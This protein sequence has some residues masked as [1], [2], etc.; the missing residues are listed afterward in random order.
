M[1]N[2]GSVPSQI[3]LVDLIDILF[4]PSFG[5]VQLFAWQLMDVKQVEIIIVDF[6][7]RIFYSSLSFYNPKGTGIDRLRIGDI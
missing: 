2:S 3:T 6:D 1:P 4:V 7:L 5:R